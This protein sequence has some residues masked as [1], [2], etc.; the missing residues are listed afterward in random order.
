LKNAAST[1]WSAS[2]QTDWKI[3]QLSWRCIYPPSGAG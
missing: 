2:R 1:I 3:D